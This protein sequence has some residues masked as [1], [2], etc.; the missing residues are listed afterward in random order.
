MI[1]QQ[2]APKSIELHFVKNG[3]ECRFIYIC[4]KIVYAINTTCN[5]N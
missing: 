5:R 2:E 3:I 4:V 1:R